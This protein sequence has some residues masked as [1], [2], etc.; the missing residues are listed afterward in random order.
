MSSQAHGS[1]FLG[2]AILMV[3]GACRPRITAGETECRALVA[4]IVSLEL[5]R[6]GYRDPALLDLRKRELENVLRA[7]VARC[8]GHPLSA[9]SMACAER[10]H[11]SEELAHRCLGHER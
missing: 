2:A 9:E 1:S 5:A 8:V 10:A 7:D 6:L 4:R 3:L 11:A